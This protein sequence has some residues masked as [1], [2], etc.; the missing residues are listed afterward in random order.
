MD[1]EEQKITWLERV[2]ELITMLADS[3]ISELEL[4]EAGTEI[5]IRRQPGMVMVPSAMQ[6]SSMGQAAMPF[7]HGAVP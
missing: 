1:T 4:T 3:T 6:Q 2:E 7:T 5:I